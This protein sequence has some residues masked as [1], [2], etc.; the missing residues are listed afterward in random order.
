MNAFF[1]YNFQKEIIMKIIEGRTGLIYCWKYKDG[2][3]YVGQCFTD[4]ERVRKWQHINY[5]KHKRHDIFHDLL[6]SDYANFTYT[7]LERDIPTPFDFV[8]NIYDRSQTNEREKYWVEQMKA[9]TEGFNENAGG[10]CGYSES[11]S[12]MEGKK[13][14]EQSR[15]MTG[16]QYARGKTWSLS[17]ETKAK[18]RKPKSDETKAKMSA[19]QKGKPKSDETK[20][21][22]KLAWVKRKEKMKRDK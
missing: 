8:N 17:E 9:W 20:A 15:K 22:L 7:V 18:M 3:C 16:N 5:N 11:Y 2:R 12:C 1:V 13:N 10:D 19:W 4:R 14:P 6:E 21:A